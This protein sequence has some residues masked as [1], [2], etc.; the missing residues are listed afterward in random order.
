MTPLQMKY[1][2][3]VCH[4]QNISKAAASLH[5]SQPT[6]TV[7]IQSLESELGI[8]LF[9][10]NGKHLLLTKEGTI[11]WDKVANILSHIEQ[12]ENE[13]RDVAHNKNHIRLGVP[14]QI[15]V[16]LLPKLFNE[17]KTLHPEINLDICEAGGIEALQLIERDELDMAI[18]NY[19][20]NF[21]E[22][23]IYKKV[24]ENEICFCTSP[25]NPL[26]AKQYITPEDIANE[27]LVMLSGGFFINRAVNSMFQVSGIKP[28]I[29]LY[30]SQLHTIKNMVNHAFCSTFLMR[31]AITKDD[32]IVVIPI[33][34]AYF[35]NSGI[36][37]KK[38]KPIYS[39]EQALLDF[40]KNSYAK[41][42][43]K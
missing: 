25:Q 2:D 16:K 22:N 14:L 27:K 32:N 13:I 36:V 26:S 9:Y 7:A 43:E 29:L 15:G 12:L 1:F 24:G 18:T 4:F 33:K 31:Q 28:E 8:K 23:L 35:I 30:S 39:D 3:A 38:G 41:Q 17:F 19:D 40:L 37:M 42:V 21:S 6:I 20:N 34:P 5:I 10:R 11:I